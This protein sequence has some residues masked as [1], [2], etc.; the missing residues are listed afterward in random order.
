MSLDFA[1]DYNGPIVIKYPRG[2]AFFRE[3]G[4]VPAPIEYGKA[5]IIKKEKDILLLAVGDMVETALEVYDGLKDMGRKATVVNMRFV[6]PFDK[7]L[8]LSLCKKHKTIVTLEDGVQTGGFGQQVK[9]LLFENKCQ[10][11]C[12]SICLPD[13]FIEHGSPE[14]LKEKY[15]LNAAS[16]L[17]KIERGGAG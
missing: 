12:I 1:M 6:K 10:K 17:E 16:V 3:E 14:E 8:V 4:E 2:A 5:E 13:R 11:E 15:G 9:A 7:E